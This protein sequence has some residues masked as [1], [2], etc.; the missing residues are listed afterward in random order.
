MRRPALALL[1]TG[2][3]WALS[4]AP[5]AS[6]VEVEGY[7]ILSRLIEE[8]GL[9][10]EARPLDSNQA[11]VVTDPAG[12][13]EHSSGEPPGHT[14]GY[15]DMTQVT[16]LGVIESGPRAA[17][18]FRTFFAKAPGPGARA[19][20]RGGFQAS[21]ETL[22]VCTPQYRG[23][24]TFDDGAVVIGATFAA[25]LPANPDGGCEYVV[26][27]RERG[28]QTFQHVPQ[29]PNDPADG[30]NRALIVRAF[31]GQWSA[32]GVRYNGQ[33]F[34]ADPFPAAAAVR[35][36]QLA[37]FIPASE[38][39]MV[40]E[41]NYYA[42]CQT[43]GFQAETSGADQTML[44]PLDLALFPR[45][46]LTRVEASPSPSPSPSSTASPSP[47]AS[48]TPTISP[49]I[50]IDPGGT[51]SFRT[52]FIVLIAIGGVLIPVGIWVYHQTRERPRPTPGGSVPEEP[53]PGPTPG[54]SMTRDRPVEYAH[55]DWAAYYSPGGGA[56]DVVLRE[57]KGKECCVYRISV[58]TTVSKDDAAARGRQEPDLLG[59]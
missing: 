4:T 33:F 37:F 46:Q 51:G 14:P 47:T 19:C 8:S 18:L 42:F 22:G 27:L 17:D 54:G 29:F 21:P 5:A 13:F 24:R 50:V 39:A 9:D 56:P 49:V 11:I 48:P 44:V 34:A 43:G 57:A 25:P 12:D 10:I 36:N 26:W 3:A 2:L 6:Q 7:D 1:V 52:L 23:P 40:E 20:D 28:A 53:G 15:V 58:T 31:G 41:A 16:K 35:G 30:T 55:C 59:G 32:T 45:F 38:L